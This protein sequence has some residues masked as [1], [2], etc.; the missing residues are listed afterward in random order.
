MFIRA[1]RRREAHVM[2]RP[3]KTAALS[4]AAAWLLLAAAASAQTIE[5]KVSH[6]LPPNHTFQKALLA[7]GEELEKASNG[8]LKLTIYPAAQLGPPPRQLDI[9]RS[10]V[11]DIAV[12]LHGLTPGR[13][14]LTELVSAPYAAPQAGVLSAVTSKRLTELAPD[15]LVKEHEGVRILWMAVT[16]PLM[17]I[18]RPPIRTLEDFKGLKIRYAGTNFKAIIDALG[19]VGLP[20]PPPETQD[21]MAKGIVDAATFPY[22]G[23][24]SFDLG[25]VAK[26]ALEPGVSSATFAVVM[27][28]AKYDALPADLK[29]LIAKTTGP[30]RAERFGAMWDEAEK[31]G[32]ENL[33]SHGVQPFAMSGPDFARVKQAL[34]PLVDQAIADVE[35]KG[36]PGKKFYSDYTR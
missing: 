8:K 5:L 34:A 3:I 26:Y 13:Y 18:S 32:K 28:Q 2:L 17:F 10:G 9:A 33:L 11:V 23:A 21:A 24:A 4:L 15:Y 6:F 14:A 25:T 35:K 29:D 7:W 19:G 20:V 30:A 27:N 1:P 36:L 22:E 16:P 12:G 31:A